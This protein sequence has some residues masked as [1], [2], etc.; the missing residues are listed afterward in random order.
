M[1]L[2]HNLDSKKT[3]IPFNLF[4]RDSWFF[5]HDNWCIWSII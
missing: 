3:I 2:Y 1:K 5:K 4:I